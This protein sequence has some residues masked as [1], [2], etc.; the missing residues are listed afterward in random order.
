M[1]KEHEHRV[2]IAT[3]DGKRIARHFRSA[4]YFLVYTVRRGRL[5]SVETR[6]NVHASLPEAGEG[7]AECW[8]VLEDLLGDVRVVIVSGMGENAYVGMLR[9]DVLPLLTSEE[10]VE[11]A[12]EEYLRGRL[13][14]S[15]QLVH[16]TDMG[17]GKAR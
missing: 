6:T 3:D 2:A 9:R 12:M 1:A 10:R 16:R 8:K 7:H 4:P 14:E 17:T 5:L 15:P 11:R 13:K